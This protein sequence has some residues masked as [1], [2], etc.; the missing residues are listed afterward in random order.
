MSAFIAWPLNPIPARG[1]I[2]PPPVEIFWLS[3]INK[4]RKSLSTNLPPARRGTI[5]SILADVP[6]SIIGNKSVR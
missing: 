2:D 4:R 3:N 1:Q 6:S 5:L